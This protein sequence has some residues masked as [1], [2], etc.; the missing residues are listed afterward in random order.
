M[1]KKFILS[2]VLALLLPMSLASCFGKGHLPVSDSHIV[3]DRMEQLKTALNNGDKEQLK[4]MFSKQ[5]L[6]EAE[7]FDENL[8]ALFGLVDGE[9]ISWDRSSGSITDESFDHGH[10]TKQVLS[11]YKMNTADQEYAVFI[12]VH[13]VDTDTP[14]NVGLYSL[15]VVRAEDK[16]KLM[17]YWQ[18]MN[19][20]GIYYPEE[21]RATDKKPE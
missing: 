20:P 6:S 13:A 3:D 4:G 8:E 1:K 10:K 2:F 21:Y 7:R 9:I 15:R 16:G 18:H 17:G 11:F 19:I 12:L 14:D 5:A